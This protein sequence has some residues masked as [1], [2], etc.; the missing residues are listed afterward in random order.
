MKWLKDKLT[1]AEAEAVKAPSNET[2]KALAEAKTDIE[3]YM[4]LVRQ[5]G[6]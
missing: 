4:K 6:Y 1:K 5:G 3:N 2:A